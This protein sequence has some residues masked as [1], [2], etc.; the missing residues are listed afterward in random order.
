MLPLGTIPCCMYS[1]HLWTQCYNQP[2]L[3]WWEPNAKWYR[4]LTLCLV[5]S[6]VTRWIEAMNFKTCICLLLTLLIFFFNISYC[7]SSM[8]SNRH[9]PNMRGIIENCQQS[10][11][12]SLKKFLVLGEFRRGLHDRHSSEK[13]YLA[14]TEKP[15]LLLTLFFCC[16]VQGCVHV[17]LWPVFLFWSPVGG[18][19]I[20]RY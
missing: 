1:W 7:L 8:F 20:T 11:L 10:S 13:W 12:E 6:L 18:H 9:H 5:W 17:F 16:R 14:N 19:K 3:L 2:Y 15:S 4:G